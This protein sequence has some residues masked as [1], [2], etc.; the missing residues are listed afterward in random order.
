MDAIAATLG[1]VKERD[2]LSLR[3]EGA[4]HNE[5]SWRERVHLPLTFLLQPRA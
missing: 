2:L 4:D 1:Y 3:F 5:Q